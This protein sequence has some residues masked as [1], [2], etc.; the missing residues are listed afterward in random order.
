MLFRQFIQSQG[1]FSITIVGIKKFFCRGH[2]INVMLN[3]GRK[4]WQDFRK[5][6]NCGKE[7]QINLRI[8]ESCQV[9]QHR[10]P[11][12]LPHPNNFSQVTPLLCRISIYSSHDLPIR[13]LNEETGYGTA[14]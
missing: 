13:F 10:N 2:N 11:Q 4:R 5:C 1:L 6:R 8:L 9:M 3:Q 7:G 14:N 12:S